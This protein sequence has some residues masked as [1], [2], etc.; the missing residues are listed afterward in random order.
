MSKPAQSPIAHDVSSLKDADFARVSE[1][2]KSFKFFKK[3]NDPRFGDISIIQ[4]PQTRQF[5]ALKEKKINDRKEA[6]QNILYARKR[7]SLKH[8]NLLNL[9][10]YSV[11]KHSEL[12]SSFYILKLFFE[13]PKTDLRKDVQERERIGESF[14][15]I[16]L[17]HLLYQQINA[18][19]FLASKDISHGDIQPLHIG[20]DRDTYTSKLIERFEDVV[21][22]PNRTK[23][24]QKNRL[25]S[26]QPLYMSPQMY[27]NLKKGNLNFDVDHSKEDAFALGLTILETGNSRSIQNIYDAKTGSV[28]KEVL[29]SHNNQFA[30]RYGGPNSLLPKSVASLTAYNENERLNFRE[31]EARLP[32]YEK[33]KNSLSSGIRNVQGAPIVIET[34]VRDPRVESYPG[35]FNGEGHYSDVNP[36]IQTDVYSHYVHANPQ[37]DNAPRQIVNLSEYNNDAPKDSTQNTTIYSYNQ[38]TTMTYA[39]YSQPYQE[40]YHY[41]YAQPQVQHIEQVVYSQYD[42]SITQNRIVHAEPVIVN[43][44]ITSQVVNQNIANVS[45]LKLVKT[46]LD[47]TNA[48]DRPNY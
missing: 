36:G 5:I 43:Q 32:D 33:V 12:C 25:I 28:N 20:Y 38:P 6:G 48:T 16:E 2:E 14:S 11:T 31:L 23:Q 9:L 1:L 46:Y 29:D 47:P 39:T 27:Q 21:N 35:L 30:N 34:E 13:Y 4:N 22:V 26:G 17:T 7:V 40:N 37:V 42:G 3:I 19:S 10:D 45:G 44:T 15:D 18:N 24:I 41:T 8:P